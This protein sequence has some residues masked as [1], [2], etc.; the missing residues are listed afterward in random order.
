MRDIDAY[1]VDD[2]IGPNVRP[3]HKTSGGPSGP[4]IESTH[5]PMDVPVLNKMYLF[6]TTF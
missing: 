6:L 3:S 5:T 2:V 1:I 4:F